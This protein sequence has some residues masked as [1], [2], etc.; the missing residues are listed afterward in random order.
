MNETTKALAALRRRADLNAPQRRQEAHRVKAAAY[1]AAIS[2]MELPAVFDFHG[3]HQVTVHSVARQDRSIVF[4]LTWTIDG[5][6]QSWPGA[7]PGRPGEWRLV[8]PPI[9][10]SDPAGN[11]ALTRRNPI[12]KELVITRFREDISAAF[13]QQL[14]ALITRRSER[15]SRAQR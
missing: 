1:L 9:Y 5:V 12:T 4:M 13:T 6:R 11:V 7:R 14:K 10:V 8:N 15:R 3:G 2:R